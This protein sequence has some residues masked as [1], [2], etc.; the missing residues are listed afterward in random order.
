MVYPKVVKYYSYALVTE[1]LR[2]FI[3][4][5]PGFQG[6]Q[7]WQ[8]FPTLTVQLNYV[9]PTNIDQKSEIQYDSRASEGTTVNEG[10]R[11]LCR[12]YSN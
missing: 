12:S 8:R 6:S 9:Q 7:K 1:N 2:F 4:S 11:D 3:L 10:G 5:L